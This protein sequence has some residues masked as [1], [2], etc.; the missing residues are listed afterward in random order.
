VVNSPPSNNTKSNFS[1]IK[2]YT[3]G[4][5]FIFS[6]SIEFH[7]RYSS[8]SAISGNTFIILSISD[9][10]RIDPHTI[11]RLSPAFISDWVFSIANAFFSRLHSK[12]IKRVRVLFRRA[13]KKQRVLPNPFQVPI[14]KTFSNCGLARTVSII[15]LPDKV[16]GLI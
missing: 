7:R 3:Y 9:P 11:S 16:S 2:P 10:S 6:T 5:L 1:G 14:S 15:F 12:E 4:A 13:S 8:F